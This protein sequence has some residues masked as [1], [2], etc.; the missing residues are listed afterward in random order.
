M[1]FFR[2]S[3][4]M[5][6]M[7][8]S[9]GRRAERREHAPAVRPSGVWGKGRAWVRPAAAHHTVTARVTHQRTRAHNPRST[10]KN[11]R[12]HRG[13][14]AGGAAPATHHGLGLS[15]VLLVAQHAD[16]HDG[17]GGHRQAERAVE[18]LVLGGIVVLQGCMQNGA[19]DRGRG[20]G[21]APVEGL[22][23]EPLP[24]TGRRA[25]LNTRARGVR[26]QLRAPIESCPPAMRGSQRGTPRAPANKVPG[27]GAGGGGGHLLCTQGRPTH[28]HR[29][30]A[31]RSPG[32]SA[33]C[34]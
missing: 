12:G 4:D 14:G 1:N 34:P 29:S 28:T 15:A 33:S 23:S 3:A 20:R 27:G 18:T 6:S 22:R 17:A 13:G 16:G 19:S 5:A 8:C 21:G 10:T 30:A 9:Q 31:P 11:T 25:T 26:V 2:S 32:I 24:A 7:P